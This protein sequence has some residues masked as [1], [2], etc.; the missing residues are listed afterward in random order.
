M[1]WMDFP[2]H[3]L[4]L[5][6]LIEV[7]LFILSIKYFINSLAFIGSKV[8]EMLDGFYFV[9][10]YKLE[11]LIRLAG[12]L[13]KKPHL[14]S[15]RT[16]GVCLEQQSNKFPFVNFQYQSSFLHD[17]SYNFLDV[18]NASLNLQHHFCLAIFLA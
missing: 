17:Q 15:C 9:P 5:M 2:I 13:A 14:S 16:L 18:V 10:K 7:S 12:G 1:L 6:S 4:H 8:K 11:P 3:W